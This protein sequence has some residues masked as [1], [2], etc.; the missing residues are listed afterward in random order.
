MNAAAK[1]KTRPLH[2]AASKGY[3]RVVEVLI[4]RGPILML[5]ISLAFTGL[6]AAERNNHMDV[7]DFLKTA[8]A[9]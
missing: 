5:E 8:G 9:K 3:K 7:V 2:W 6:L 1:N 4:N